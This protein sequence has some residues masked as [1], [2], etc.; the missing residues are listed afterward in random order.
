[1]SALS[2]ESDS[3]SFVKERFLRV[4]V[5]DGDD[6]DGGGGGND[7]GEDGDMICI[8]QRRVKEIAC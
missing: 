2:I 5:H 1:M 7:D 6:D 8:C 3:S 4:H